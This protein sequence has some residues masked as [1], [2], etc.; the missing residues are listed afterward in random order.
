MP[1]LNRPRGDTRWRRR[2]EYVPTPPAPE[3]RIVT[4]EPEPVVI[5]DWFDEVMTEESQ[6]VDTPVV[7]TVH[8]SA[9]GYIS[10]REMSQLREQRYNE[11]QRQ[12]LETRQRQMPIDPWRR[13]PSYARTMGVEIPVQPSREVTVEFDE[14]DA[15]IRT[16]SI[17]RPSGYWKLRNGRFIRIRD[18]DD[19]HLENCIRMCQRNSQARGRRA[20]PSAQGVYSELIGE[21]NNR[22]SVRD[23]ARRLGEAAIEDQQRR[24]SLE[25][26]TDPIAE[27]RSWNMQYSEMVGQRLAGLASDL[28]RTPVA[29]DPEPELAPGVIPEGAPKRRIKT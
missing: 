8:D 27:L 22:V 28:A 4:P 20:D 10:Q 14:S 29:P 25:S 6:E 11:H 12:I 15:R 26:N 17:E 16:R 2:E 24:Q 18:M 23:A 7:G 1:P 3:A 9:E 21:R 13:G 19:D 5:E